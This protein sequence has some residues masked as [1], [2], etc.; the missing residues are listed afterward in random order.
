MNRHIAPLIGLLALLTAC[1]ADLLNANSSPAYAKGYQDGCANGSSTAS[2]ANGMFVRDESRYLNDPEYARGWRTGNRM[3][4]GDHFN[5]N[6][7]DPMEPIQ[8][9]GM[10][11]TYGR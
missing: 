3:C 2:N 6:P 11:G 9:D 8:I 5:A 10:G 7:N 1:S 4:N